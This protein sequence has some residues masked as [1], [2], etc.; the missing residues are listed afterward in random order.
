MISLNP[1]HPTV[2]RRH[3]AKQHLFRLYCQT[4][5]LCI[6]LLGFADIQG[7]SRSEFQVRHSFTQLLV[8]HVVFSV[9]LSSQHAVITLL[10]MEF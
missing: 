5:T 7:S 10:L 9:T 6:S 3:T 2:A 1:C 4:S 8:I